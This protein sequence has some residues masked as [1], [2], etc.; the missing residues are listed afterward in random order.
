[1][2]CI[3]LLVF[4]SA[5]CLKAAHGFIVTCAETSCWN[6]V[7]WMQVFEHLKFSSQ[8]SSSCPHALN[9]FLSPK[10]LIPWIHFFVKVFASFLNL[11]PV[12]YTEMCYWFS[13][14]REFPWMTDFKLYSTVD[15][16]YT[17]HHPDLLGLL[18]F[19]L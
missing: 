1:M 15:R 17:L 19:M 4:C 8:E 5:Y 7:C 6:T 2:W 3:C 12:N 9:P 16:E 14:T 11:W 13:A 10:Y 18:R